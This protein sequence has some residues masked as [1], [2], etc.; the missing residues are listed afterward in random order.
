MAHFR[1]GLLELKYFLSNLYSL[2][3]NVP[4]LFFFLFLFTSPPNLH[5]FYDFFLALAFWS[6]VYSSPSPTVLLPVP[7]FTRLCG[8]SNNQ[9]IKPW[10]Q[11][12]RRRRWPGCFFFLF[13]F[14]STLTSYMW[15]PRGAFSDFFILGPWGQSMLRRLPSEGCNLYG[16]MVSFGFWICWVT[17]NE[18]IRY[19][20]I[21]VLKRIKERK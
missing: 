16:K 15:L 5:V 9:T 12:Q 8:W 1:A 11:W 6:T 20:A 7:F 17:C 21:K 4:C 3:P 18:N 2:M 13:S 19:I 10:W 14:F